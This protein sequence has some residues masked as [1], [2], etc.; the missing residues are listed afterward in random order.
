MC[1]DTRIELLKVVN[2]A[3]EDL[4]ILQAVLPAGSTSEGKHRCT[5]LQPPHMHLHHTQASVKASFIVSIMDVTST[6]AGSAC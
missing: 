2:I 5:P 3:A 1:F 6:D 4:D